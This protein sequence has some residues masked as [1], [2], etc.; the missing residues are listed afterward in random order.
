MWRG[1]VVFPAGAVSWRSA[2]TLP[3]G[4][5]TRKAGRMPALRTRGSS[6]SQIGSTRL[7]LRTCCERGPLAVRG[8]VGAP[9]KSRHPQPV[10]SRRN[11]RRFGVQEL[12][13]AIRTG[14]EVGQISPVQQ[15]G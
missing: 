13:V 11:F 5:G 1:P 14:A 3:P 12:E 4:R 2:E 7:A 10:E 15:V 8:K 6:K 9:A